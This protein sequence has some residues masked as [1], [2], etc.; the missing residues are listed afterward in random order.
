M[1]S[2]WTGLKAVKCAVEERENTWELC[3]FLT[4]DGVIHGPSASSA[5]FP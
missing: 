2:L 1:V 3:I 5:V 4:L